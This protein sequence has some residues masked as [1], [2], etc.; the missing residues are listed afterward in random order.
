MG[1]GADRRVRG[2]GEKFYQGLIDGF[3]AFAAFQFDMAE[4]V[5]GSPK[6]EHL[7]S[8]Y[9]QTGRMPEAL[10]NA[11]VLPAGCGQLWGD[12][13][14]IHG[15]RAFD[16]NGP[17]RITFRDIADWQGFYGADLASWEIAAIRK[18]D[19]AYMASRAK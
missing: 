8:A 1:T 17:A 10:A 3:A 2:G 14:E 16:M 18:A 5:E 6:R 11:P 7:M 13:L 19:D 9:R 4:L 15:A 12:F